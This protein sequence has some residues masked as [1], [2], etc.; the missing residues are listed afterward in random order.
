MECKIRKPGLVATFPFSSTMELTLPPPLPH[1]PCHRSTEAPPLSEP[2]ASP[3]SGRSHRCRP[4]AHAPVPEWR[5]QFA[6]CFSKPA[7]RPTA[8]RSTSLA[9]PEQSPPAVLGESFR[10][11]SCSCSPRASPAVVLLLAEHV[12]NHH[13]P[14][15]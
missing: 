6:S 15:R 14:A 12:G 8:V 13:A 5:P 11:P 3:S 2:S 10:L 4:Q 1:R 9:I 7:E